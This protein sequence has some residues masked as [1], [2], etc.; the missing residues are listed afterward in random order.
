MGMCSTLLNLWKEKEENRFFTV[1][2]CYIFKFTGRKHNP[3]N[4]VTQV[5]T[6]KDGT[7]SCHFQEDADANDQ[8]KRKF[9]SYHKITF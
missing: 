8:T 3:H 6:K 9:D 5:H 4:F 2:N 7:L 1:I